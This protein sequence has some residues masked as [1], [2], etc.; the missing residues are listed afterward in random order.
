MAAHVLEHFDDAP[1][2]LEKMYRMLGKGGSLYLIIPDD[3]DL[4]NQDH[5]WFFTEGGIKM[6]LDEIGFKDVLFNSKQIVPH[7]KFFYIRGGK[8]G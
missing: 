2:M 5:K 6:W 7:E 8:H 3:T 1:G 4:G